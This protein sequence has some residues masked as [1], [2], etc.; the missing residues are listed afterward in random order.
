[1]LEDAQNQALLKRDKVFHDCVNKM[2]EEFFR[3]IDQEMHNLD[4]SSIF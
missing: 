2:E 3:F 1:M 4:E